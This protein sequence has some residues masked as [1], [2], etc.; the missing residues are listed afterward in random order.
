MAKSAVLC[1]KQCIKIC[2]KQ[3][4]NSAI[5]QNDNEPN[6]QEK[7]KTSKMKLYR[8]IYVQPK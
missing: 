4:H 3:L 2:K 6:V 7:G 1:D 5:Q 8:M